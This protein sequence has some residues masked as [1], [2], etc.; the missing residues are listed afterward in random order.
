VSDSLDLSGQ[1]LVAVP[2]GLRGRDDLVSLDLSD[3][4]LTA[5]P[6]WIDEL[7]GLRHLN[8]RGNRLGELPESLGRLVGLETLDLADNE[9]TDLDPW[10]L[11]KLENLRRLGLSRNR[12]QTLPYPV[13]LMPAIEGFD[14]G[15]SGQV[16]SITRWGDVRY[17]DGSVSIWL[18]AYYDANNS[19]I[20]RFDVCHAENSCGKRCHPAGL[21]PIH[22][23]YRTPPRPPAF[24]HQAKTDHKQRS[25]LHDNNGSG[26]MQQQTC[27]NRIREAVRT[28]PPT[29]P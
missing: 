24:T 18:D 9:L 1:G 11:P 3:N 14:L 26:P 29:S 27:L 17:R 22:T 15:D 5:L 10:T 25:N 23:R 21:C 19:V 6:A 8:L 2:D 28:S 16:T 12:L 7:T 4:A 20:G 13:D